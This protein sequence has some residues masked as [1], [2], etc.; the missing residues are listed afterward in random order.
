[1]NTNLTP[2]AD[3]FVPSFG[4]MNI[5]A[6]EWKPPPLAAD[7]RV[8]AS[9][10]YASV[11]EYPRNEYPAMGFNW[12]SGISSMFPTTIPSPP[13][14]TLRSMG[15][16][17]PLRLY[18]QSLDL[19]SLRQISPD[20][21]RY[22]EIPTRFH[23]IFYLDKSDKSQNTG[24]SFGYPSATYKVIDR[25]DSQSY[26]L[27]RFEN[28]K[29]NQ[30][31]T[32][33]SLAKWLPIKHPAIISLN[34]ISQEKG[35]TFFSHAYH[36]LAVTLK[37]KFIERLGPILREEL[38]WSMLSQLLLG[39][40]LVHKNGLAIRVVDINHVLLTPGFRVRYGCVG[41]SDVLDFESRK[42]V[43][44]LQVEDM[45][46]L[47]ILLVS[48]AARINFSY[49]SIEQ[50][51]A[52]IRQNYSSQ[53]CD[54]IDVLLLGKTEI[55]EILKMF[56]E[57]ICDEFDVNL[58][59]FESLHEHLRHEYENSRL[60]R[61]LIKFGFVNERTDNA[62]SSAWSETGDRYVLKLFRDFLF[63][64]RLPDNSPV[65][66]CGHVIS[67]LNKVDAGDD[68]EILLSSRDGKDVLVVTYA[69]ISRCLE[70]SF[71]ELSSQAE[72]LNVSGYSS[73]S[74]GLGGVSSFIPEDVM[75]FRNT[76]LIRVRSD[77]TLTDRGRFHIGLNG[78]GVGNRRF[79]VSGQNGG[80][81]RGLNNKKF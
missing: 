22:K 78:A 8:E 2:R 35:A 53:F 31:V 73:P 76:N 32:K 52:M 20:D 77:D 50:G 54:M 55:T 21:D 26:A 5:A 57:R 46:K 6:S 7:C 12:K 24:G 48:S 79:D 47:G 28:V 56:S 63:H 60:N 27:R 41:I 10:E 17:E 16:P 39:M 69:D 61:L 80:R 43:K 42:S 13:K 1:M 72:K 38:V 81:C 68:E 67:S 9:E 18:F 45:Q 62:T 44:E 3:S 74:T 59:S 37:E 30:S 11:T 64:Q 34:S 40:R 36:P 58:A 33:N 14:K 23:T 4:G 51:R 29:I 49:S 65:L 19:E 75:Y 66:E 15:V 70:N 71:V 25:F